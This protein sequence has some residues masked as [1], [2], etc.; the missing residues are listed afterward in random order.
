MSAPC[1]RPDA[2]A[3]RLH[4]DNSEA[5]LALWSRVRHAASP[6]PGDGP[7]LCVLA[8]AA[9]AV[10]H[11]TGAAPSVGG[12]TTGQTAPWEVRV[13]TTP[14]PLPAGRCAAIW[15][16]IVDTDGYRH[17]TM[18]SGAVLN[19]AAFTYATSNATDF[20]WQTGN[21]ATGY[22]CT[23]AT[24][25]A[26]QTTITVTLPNGT[27]GTVRLANVATGRYAPPTI[28][29]PQAPIWRPG[30]TGTRATTASPPLSTQ[31]SGAGARGGTSGAATGGGGATAAGPPG[32]V[33]GAPG[34]AGPSSAPGSVGPGGAAPGSGA[35][36]GAA[37]A[38][39]AT[40]TA[41]GSGAPGDGTTG[42]APSTSAGAAPGAAGSAV[43]TS[44]DSGSTKRLTPGG[45]A[46]GSAPILAP[47]TVTTGALAITGPYVAL[48]PLTVTTEALAI[49]G[50]FTPIAT[51]TVVTSPLSIT[52]PSVALPAPTVPTSSRSITGPVAH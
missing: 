40:G 12:Q 32:T 36:A 18:Q 23:A 34:G 49:T 1:V 27:S 37:A 44:T 3:P 51:Q 9:L 15:I 45:I 33:G 46:P 5:H 22:I 2:M 7:C 24:T 39:A 42:A 43:G 41:A 47:V 17:T 25:G 14:N 38:G 11:A 50:P 31:P 19:P 30:M 21:P 35:T 29:R 16:E 4:P 20:Q 8:A 26:A 6:P 10:A 52:G 48:G 13:T 28:F